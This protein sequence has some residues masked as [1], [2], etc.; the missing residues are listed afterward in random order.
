MRK[1]YFFPL[2]FLLFSLL[3]FSQ[4]NLL[5]NPSFEDSFIV[6]SENFNDWAINFNTIRTKVT[7]ATDGTY[8][9]KIQTN[10]S[11]SNGFFAE[12]SAATPSNDLAFENGKTYTISFDYKV[13]TGT[14][15]EL[16]ATLQRDNFYLEDEEILTNLTASGWQTFSYDF[17]AGFTAAHN[18]DINLFGDTASAEIIIDNASVIEKIENP[19]RDALIALYN[20]TEGA[21]WS[22]AGTQW[23][24][25][26]DI[27]TWYGVTLNES[28]RVIE[29]DLRLRNL[30]GSLPAE[31]GDL[32]E[33]ETL[34]LFANRLSG[35]LPTE[36]WNLTKL[37]TLD[38]SSN[39]GFTGTIP[40]TIQNL[41][42]LEVLKI[43]GDLDT[44]VLSG[45]IPQ[46][47]GNLSAL[48]ELSLSSNNFS[49]TFPIQ[50]TSLSQ[51][52]SLDLNGNQLSGTIP[53]EIGNLSQL[54]ELRIANN[55][56]TGSIPSEVGNLSQL[57]KLQI[58]YNNLSGAIPT[59]IGNLS[60]LTYFSF[61]E[62][63][64]SGSIPAELTNLT[65]LQL[66]NA[67]NC[68]L[69]GIIPQDI[70]NMNQLE[71]FNAINCDLSGTLPNSIGDLTQL[72][73]LWLT[74]N[75]LFGDIPSSIGN[76]MNLVSLRLGGNNLT[77]NI[78]ANIGNLSS[79]RIIDLSYNNITGTVPTN[80]G[81][82]SLLTS[83][84][85]S[86]NSLEGAIPSSIGNLPN[87]IS[88][89]AAINNL[90]GPIPIFTSSNIVE[91]YLRNNNYVFEALEVVLASAPNTSIYD[92]NFQ[93]EVDNTFSV[94]LNS[95]D[96]FT[97]MV[98]DTSS[99][100]NIYEWRKNGFVIEGGSERTLTISN[101]STADSGGYNCFITN[102]T[103]PNLR[104]I[105]NQITLT[106]NGSNDLDNDGVLNDSDICPN[107]P[108]GETVNANGCSGS[109]L[110]DDN[111]GVPN[112]IDQCP[113]TP[114]EYTVDNEGCQ[115]T[116][117]DTDNDEDGVYDADDQCPNTPIGE[118]VDSN[119]CSQSQL[120][121]DN[122]GVT[123]NLDNCPN[124]PSGESVD[125]IGCATNQ[126]ETPLINNN[127]IEVQVVSTSCPNKANGEINIS[128][129]KDYSYVVNLTGTKN[130][131]FQNVSF[132][133]GLSIGGLL[134]GAYDVCVTIPEYPNFERCFTVVIEIPEAFTTGKA[135][136][137]YAKKTA[138][139]V[140]SGSK[141]YAVLVNNKEFSY[142]FNDTGMHELAFEL[143]D[144][145]NTIL[146]KTDKNCQ[147][148]YQ[149]TYVLKRVMVSPNP[150]SG[151]EAIILGLLNSDNAIITISDSGGALLKRLKLNIQN[152]MIKLPITDLPTGLYY[153]NIKSKEQDVQTKMIKR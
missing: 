27:S 7:D 86:S 139:L 6:A 126:T 138:K 113:D 135:A 151:E 75:S 50:L 11:G 1:N 120:D 51:L 78:P 81:N 33:L 71:Y 60:N 4:T 92:Y 127:D 9:V 121:D 91:V 88:F 85:L 130:E 17:T 56:L 28:G 114:E 119:G 76:L 66:F 96:D 43:S 137:D 14:I 144:G 29:L 8:A 58:N 12:L 63:N 30:I 46:E 141:N 3:G 116:Q 83:I 42:S 26:A 19:D 87:L 21:N 106:V 140:V 54:Q 47:I 149:E 41:Q 98:E 102:S 72:N 65:Q 80:L 104:L 143:V 115:L 101:V 74:G 57:E 153:I 49:G 34:D 150:T 110:D 111:D 55:L 62:N 36:I 39:I 16:K 97:I 124:T 107:T 99:S 35:P 37:I 38:L 31:I 2:L 152:G 5:K 94:T 25:N 112:N 23:D 18:F 24:L 45:G 93:N 52:I 103:V 73:S 95:G 67:E 61:S 89:R 15:T 108:T 77:G 117:T 133:N 147:G 40:S 59:E 146:A 129:N 10:R 136:V 131:T 48:K 70:G 90:S 142:S 122:D 123:N 13:E 32:S 64:I 84:N 82:L 53:P 128:F 20:A 69:S 68:S 44:N 145:A 134:P 22:G 79:I 118:T 125:A 100:N 105:K 109:Q 132:T 148:E